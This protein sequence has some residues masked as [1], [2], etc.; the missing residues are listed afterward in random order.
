MENY[1]KPEQY[2]AEMTTELSRILSY[3]MDY[4]R[5]DV[6]GGIT[7]KI[8]HDNHVFTDAPK[9]SVLHARVLW[10]FSSAYN[11]AGDKKY[12]D[13][14]ERAYTYIVSHFADNTHG[15]FYWTVDHHG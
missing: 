10:T 6:N 15:G 11:L 8:D 1:I 13:M 5:D 2:H 12:L 9:G 3:W 7:G 14:A 4:A